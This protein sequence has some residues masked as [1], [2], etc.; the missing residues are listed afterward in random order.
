MLDFYLN[1]AR[2]ANCHMQ[3]ALSNYRAVTAETGSRRRAD[4]HAGG[5]TGKAGPVG[6]FAA[7]S[8]RLGIVP[9]QPGVDRNRGVDRNGR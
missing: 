5:G 8:G 2:V 9:G 4:Q 1:L 7:L 6:D 3:R